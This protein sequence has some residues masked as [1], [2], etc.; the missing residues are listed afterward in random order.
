MTSSQL[1]KLHSID[2]RKFLINRAE[3]LTRQNVSMSS[4][5]KIQEYFPE[6]SK[7]FFEKLLK[8]ANAIENEYIYESF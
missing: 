5:P 2:K 6:F 3:F 7:I 4:F 1:K 8:V